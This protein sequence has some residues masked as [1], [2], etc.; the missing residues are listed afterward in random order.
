MGLCSMLCGSLDGREWIHVFGWLCPFH[1]HVSLSQHCQSA[2]PQYKIKSKKKKKKKPFCYF[3]FF[4]TK[5]PRR[6]DSWAFSRGSSWTRNRTGVS[7]VEGGFLTNWAIRETWTTREVPNKQC[8]DSF[9]WTARWP[10]QTY[11]CIHSLPKL[12]FHPGC[13]ITLSRVP[14]AI[15]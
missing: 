13:H 5:Y 10:S 7:C 12:P 3:Y 11:S 4:W 9:R 1:V 14:C 8:C 6:K 2:L 15:H